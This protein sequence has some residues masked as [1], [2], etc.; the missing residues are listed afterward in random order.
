MITKE[1]ELKGENK[2]QSDN[3][4]KQDKFNNRLLDFV[5]DTAQRLNVVDKKSFL[6]LFTLFDDKIVVMC[7]KTLGNRIERLYVKQKEKLI[8]LLRNAKKI[9]VTADVWSSYRR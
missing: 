9:V 3:G 2:P 7:S 1:S 5:I 8:I 4:T 6:D